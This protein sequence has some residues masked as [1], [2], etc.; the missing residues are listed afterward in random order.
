MGSWWGGEVLP[1]RFRTS[2]NG[3]GTPVGR[4]T[5]T[6]NK[7]EESHQKSAN[8]C[9][10]TVNIFQLKRKGTHLHA[11]PHS[12]HPLSTPHGLPALVQS[13]P[14]QKPCRS[15]RPPGRRAPSAA[16]AGRRGRQGWGTPPAAG[17]LGTEDE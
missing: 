4:R 11:S 1:G 9:S 12:P 6:K 5:L 7:G 2:N 10:I 13:S 17:S 14:P 16:C 8:P 15:S 3:S